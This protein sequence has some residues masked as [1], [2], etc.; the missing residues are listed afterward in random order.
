MNQRFGDL[1]IVSVQKLSS[2]WLGTDFM[3]V[4]ACVCAHASVLTAPKLL[5]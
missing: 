2:L 5:F 3:F 1:S 4:C